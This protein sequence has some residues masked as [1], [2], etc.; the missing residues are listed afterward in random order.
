M[1]SKIF[2]TCIRI[3]LAYRRALHGYPSLAC[4]PQDISVGLCRYVAYNIQTSI[5]TRRDFFLLFFSTSAGRRF[6][7]S[8]ARLCESSIF[9]FRSFFFASLRLFLLVWRIKLK[10]CTGLSVLHS[11][12]RRTFFEGEK[13]YFL[14]RRSFRFDCSLCLLTLARVSSLKSEEER[15]PNE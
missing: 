2:K 14:P 6:F 11:I 4:V 13:F 15:Q 12:Y 7:S 10:T 9:S 3:G 8:S 1:G 5:P